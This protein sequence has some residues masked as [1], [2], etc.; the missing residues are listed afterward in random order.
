MSSTKVTDIVLANSSNIGRLAHHPLDNHILK[1][2]A[3]RF[4]N[5][6]EKHIKSKDIKNQRH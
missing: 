4:N 1:Y 6:M 2:Q 3:A 5:E